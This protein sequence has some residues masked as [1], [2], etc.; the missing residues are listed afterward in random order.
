MES[1]T[2]PTRWQGDDVERGFMRRL[3]FALLPVLVA[4]VWAVGACT[5]GNGDGNGATDG[6]GAHEEPAIRDGPDDVSS[7]IA[8]VNGV[9]ISQRS[10]NDKLEPVSMCEA[11]KVPLVAAYDANTGKHRWVA[12][13]DDQGY[14]SVRA[15]TGSRVFVAVAGGPGRNHTD[16]PQAVFLALDAKTGDEVW[17]GTEAKYKQQLPK[18]AEVLSAEPPVVGGVRLTGG[19]DDPLVAVDAKTGKQRWS[20][21]EA[22]LAYDDA[23]AVGDGAVF[24]VDGGEFREGVRNTHVVGYEIATG[25]V[26]WERMVNGYLWPWHVQ[27]DRLFVLWDNLEV[28]DTSD[29]RTVWKTGYKSP[30]SGFPRMTGVIANDELVFVSFTTVA[31]GG[32]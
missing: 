8:R 9:D 15:A 30:Q 25:K 1:R 31:S 20:Q 24:A 26:R 19:Q 22:R 18:D 13:A 21:P 6:D 4:A 23:W 27:G 17:R 14:A 29:G 11:G 32:D 3:R 2:S 7:G 5:D 16:G 12:C 28:V 10:D